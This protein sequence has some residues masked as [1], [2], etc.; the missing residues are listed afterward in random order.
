MYFPI[1]VTVFLDIEESIIVFLD[2]WLL[3]LLLDFIYNFIKLYHTF[4]VLFE[5]GFCLVLVSFPLLSSL[6][7]LLLRLNF[8]SFLRHPPDLRKFWGFDKILEC[9]L[10]FCSTLGLDLNWIFIC[11]RSLL[12][13][14]YKCY[15][16][17]T[18]L[19]LSSTVG[20]HLRSTPSVLFLQARLCFDCKDF[21][22]SLRSLCFWR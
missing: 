12:T 15:S 19:N 22:S 3:F 16:D 9:L 20:K 6:V 18:F 4:E 17:Y 5:S 14:A 1:E 8:S 7:L 10:E 2:M 11:F 13:L 21:H